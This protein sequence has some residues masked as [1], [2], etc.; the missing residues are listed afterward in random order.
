MWN[1]EVQSRKEV[2]CNDRPGHMRVLSG[3]SIRLAAVTEPQRNL[4]KY[5]LGPSKAATLCFVF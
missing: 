5:W 2:T 4:G 3:V 1:S